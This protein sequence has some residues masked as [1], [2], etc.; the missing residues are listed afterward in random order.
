MLQ[1][2]YLLSDVNLVI[3]RSLHDEDLGD[4]FVGAKFES[5]CK[6]ILVILAGLLS[7]TVMDH[8][9]GVCGGIILSLRERY[10]RNSTSVKKWSN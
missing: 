1:C 4:V 9:Q 8:I 10:G 7:P 2:T 3:L 6:R 5:N